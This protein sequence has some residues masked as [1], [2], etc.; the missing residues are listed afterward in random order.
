M[1]KIEEN[2]RNAVKVRENWQQDNTAVR[3]VESQVIG[4]GRVEL[5]GNPIAIIMDDGSLRLNTSVVRQWPTK[6]TASRLRALG[7][8]VSIKKGKLAINGREL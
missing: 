8:P 1:R 2:M 6:T 5:H 3:F 7:F 4:A